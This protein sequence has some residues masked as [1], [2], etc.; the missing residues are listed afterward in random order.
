MIVLHIIFWT[1]ALALFHTYVLYPVLVRLLAAKKCDNDIVY[2]R[3]EA[4]FGVTVIVPAHNEESVIREK[5]LSVVSSDYLADKIEILVGSDASTDSTNRIVREIVAEYKNV[6]LVEFARSGKPSILNALVELSS[7]DIIIFTDANVMFTKSTVFELI[8]HYKNSTIDLVDSNMQ[9]ND[10]RPEG[11]GMQESSYLNSDAQVKRAEGLLWGTMMGPFGGCYSIRRSK[12]TPVP[13]HFLND[14]LFIGVS[15]LANGGT[16]IREEA[17]IVYEDVANIF[18]EEYRR[19]VRISTGDFQI[20]Y[21]FLPLLFKPN[22]LAFTF[23]SHKVLRWIGPMLLIAAF[24]TSLAILLVAPS[25]VD[26]A[27]IVYLVGFFGLTLLFM[28]PV[29]DWLLRKAGV[30]VYGV[31]L[32]SYFCSVNVALLVGFVRFLRGVKHGSWR[33]TLRNQ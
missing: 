15:V 10:A 27:T 30:Q 4:D 26:V 21:A 2:S 32:L 16:A 5:L 22:A 18:Q 9:Y 19:K 17:A 28:F 31:R 12:Y 1:A 3:G 14:D 24:F 33:P 23:L 8:K 11:I 20:L 6:R 25:L 7:N 13:T 29:I